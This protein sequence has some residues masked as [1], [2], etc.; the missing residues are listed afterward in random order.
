MI[1]KDEDCIKIVEK[2]IDTSALPITIEKEIRALI[3][4]GYY[5]SIDEAI[6]DAFMTLLNVRPDLKISAAIELYKE[7]EISLSRA[8]EMA[9]VSTI[10]FKDILANKGIIRKIGARNKEELR[11]GAE[12]IKSLRK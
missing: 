7:E 3:K 12:L 8:A 4:Y 9:G 2:M 5:S 11:Q 6:K 1:Y 10:E